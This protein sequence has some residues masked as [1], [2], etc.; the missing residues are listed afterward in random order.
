[1]VCLNRDTWSS[2]NNIKQFVIFQM[3]KHLVKQLVLGLIGILHSCKSIVHPELMAQVSMN[4]IGNSPNYCPVQSMRATVMLQ[5]GGSW[6]TLGSAVT[7]HPG[8]IQCTLKTCQ[9]SH[10]NGCWKLVIAFNS[11]FVTRLWRW[12][13]VVLRL[14]SNIASIWLCPLLCSA[15]CSALLCS[16]IHYCKLRGSP[17]SWVCLV[18]ALV[19]SRGT[20]QHGCS[21]W[22]VCTSVTWASE[23][24]LYCK[25]DAVIPNINAYIPRT[26][27]QGWQSPNCQ[28]AAVEL[29]NLFFFTSIWKL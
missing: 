11:T 26:Y 23:F 1:M 14:L 5:T 27:Y 16:A 19:T 12:G 29:P 13:A 17:C 21:P 8:K 20:W 3:I 15:I 2:F 4:N 10:L 28:L 9:L 6:P 24:N 22:W 7:G 18:T 25:Y